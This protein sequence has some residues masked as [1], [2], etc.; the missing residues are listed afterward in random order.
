VV[1]GVELERGLAV[2]VGRRI[3]GGGWRLGGRWMD[4]AKQDARCKMNEW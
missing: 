2:E 1:Q 3:D 4:D